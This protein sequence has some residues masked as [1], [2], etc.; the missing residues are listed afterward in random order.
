MRK[1]KVVPMHISAV[2]ISSVLV[3]TFYYLDLVL[4]CFFS[5]IRNPS[6]LDDSTHYMYGEL[7]NSTRRFV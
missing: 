3:L 1:M 4:F 5:V 6:S 2:L 7:Y